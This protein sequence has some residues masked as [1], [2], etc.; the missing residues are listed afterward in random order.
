MNDHARQRF[1]EDQQPLFYRGV[2]WALGI[3]AV[4]A[5]IVIIVLRWWI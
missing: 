2:L 4:S 3:E 1:L 5:V